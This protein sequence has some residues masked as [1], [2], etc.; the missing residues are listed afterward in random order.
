VETHTLPPSRD[1]SVL[2]VAL[3]PS[4]VDG[5]TF[6]FSAFCWAVRPPGQDARNQ[7]GKARESRTPEIKMGVLLGR[8]PGCSGFR[9]LGAIT[10]AVRHVAH[11]LEHVARHAPVDFSGETADTDG[12]E[13]M[14]VGFSDPLG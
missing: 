14:A 7:V 12:S 8:S 6:S 5:K 13:S 2:T 1:L 3:N 10:G 4:A 11:R 9:H